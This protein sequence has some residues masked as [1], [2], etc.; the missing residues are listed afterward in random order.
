[1]TNVHLDSKVSTVIPDQNQHHHFFAKRTTPCPIPLWTVTTV[2]TCPLR[3]L[4]KCHVSSFLLYPLITKVSTEL[5]SSREFP[6]E[7]ELIPAV[8]LERNP[9]LQQPELRRGPGALHLCISKVPIMRGKIHPNQS[10]SREE[11]DK[12]QT[13]HPCCPSLLPQLH[14]INET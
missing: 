12:Y 3:M 8:L 9:L 10:L 2:T 7:T 13:S 4:K 6:G 11:C 14:T 1:M 5:E